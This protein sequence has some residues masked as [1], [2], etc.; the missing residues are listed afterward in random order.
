VTL[1]HG[2][3]AAGD[4]RDPPSPS[5]VLTG[6]PSAPAT[7]CIPGFPGGPWARGGRVGTR[8]DRGPSPAPAR[9]RGGP[10]PP[11]HAG[12]RLTFSPGSPTGPWG[13]GRPCERTEW[14]AGKG[15]REHPSPQPRGDALLGPHHLHGPADRGSLAVP[16]VPA[17]R[18]F[19][20]GVGGGRK[21]PISAAKRKKPL[22]GP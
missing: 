8:R 13:P 9:S 5:P 3:H 18:G 16:G 14:G 15:A 21:S 6:G 12:S 10:G 22:L 2:P 20:G 4:R 11:T 19:P 7:P 17:P 1:P